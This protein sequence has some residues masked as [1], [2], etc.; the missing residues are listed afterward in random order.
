MYKRQIFVCVCVFYQLYLIKL[1]AIIK[2]LNDLKLN[3][4]LWFISFIS[5]YLLSS[6]C[7]TIKMNEAKRSS[8][9]N[10][11]SKKILVHQVNQVYLLFDLNV[12]N[13]QT[14]D[15]YQAQMTKK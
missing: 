13:K 5:S 15:I 10:C 11:L 7:K 4:S 12:T 3:N 8:K 9:I 2:L 6:K 1:S 14:E